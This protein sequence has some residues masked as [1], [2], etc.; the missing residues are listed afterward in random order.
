M[1]IFS[2]GV[3]TGQLLSVNIGL[4]SRSQLSPGTVP[5]FAGRENIQSKNNNAGICH[6][7]WPSTPI[8]YRFKIG[9]YYQEIT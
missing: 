1:K 8:F 2:I 6:G 9:C 5:G 3:C 7:L 4:L